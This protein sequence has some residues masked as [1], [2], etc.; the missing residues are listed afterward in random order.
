MKPKAP[1]Y[2]GLVPTLL[3]SVLAAV[4]LPAAAQN[5]Q[6]Y[7]LADTGIAVTNFDGQTTTAVRENRT[8]RWGMRGNEK[9]SPNLTVLFQLESEVDFSTGRTDE[10]KGMFARQ[11]WLGL[12]GNFG[13]V[14]IGQTKGLYDDLSEEIDPF[15][16]DG[17]VGDFSKLAWRVNVANSRISN[18]V[19]YEAPKLAGLVVSGQYGFD[20]QASGGH[21]AFALS[22]KY[23]LRDLV[24]IAA[25][26]RPLVLPAAGVTPAQ[27]DAY[28]IGAAYRFGPVRLSASYNYG[29]LKAEKSK[30]EAY[31]VGATLDVG[32]GTAKAVYSRL[33]SELPLAKQTKKNR[34]VSVTGIGYDYPLS[35]R[36]T[37]Y[38]LGVYEDVG[39]VVSKVGIKEGSTKGVQAGMSF[40]F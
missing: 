38:A 22:A 25:Y 17:I 24:L 13:T 30:L 35:K 29:D 14:R 36:T 31:T 40:R 27:P 5:V 39:Q 11:A 23:E 10:E 3:A 12:K 28:M 20:E 21:S 37:L 19:T 1:A 26:D 2:N 4:S 8:G 6:L 15:R 32:G 33:N 18:S 34:D 16:N 9:I 7:G